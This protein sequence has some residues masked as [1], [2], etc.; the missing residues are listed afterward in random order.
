MRVAHRTPHHKHKYCV[1]CGHSRLGRPR[2]H[3]RADKTQRIGCE[4]VDA[5]CVMAGR[6]QRRGSCA[7]AYAWVL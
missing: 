2:C 5:Q 6:V 7:L 4:S 3:A 1:G